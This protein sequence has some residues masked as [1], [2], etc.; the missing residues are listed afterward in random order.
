[1]G[2]PA[3]MS[4]EQREGKPTDART[5]IYSFGCVL[6]EMS[7]GARIGSQ[8]GS[9]RR[10]LPSP[11]LEKIVS[12]CVQEDPAGRWQSVADLEPELASISP[13][14]GPWKRI[15]AGAAAL[16][17]VSAGAW[18]YLHR[19]P[20]LAAKDTVVLADFVNNTGDPIFDSTLRQGLAIQLEQSPFAKNNGRR[21][22]AER[23]SPDESSAEHPLHQSN[24]ARNLR[25]RRSRGHHR[26]HHREP[27]EEVRPYARGNRLSGR[28]YARPGTDPGRRQRTRVECIGNGR[29]EHARQAGRIAQLDSEAKPPAG[30]GHHCFAGSSSELH[31]GSC[32]DGEEPD[33][34]RHCV[35]SARHRNR[36]KFRH[37][38]L[39]P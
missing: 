2:T 20:K 39:P 3:Y 8:I 11:K 13:A 31:R 1:M 29:G 27:G 32:R 4:P 37:S 10:R 30:T 17:A 34:S 21:A 26:R 7:T 18:F 19:P 5:D 15:V 6:Y 24:C 35:V 33:C 14:A 25:P 16:G 22:D 38:L 12:R 36:S 28:R 23:P 9:Q